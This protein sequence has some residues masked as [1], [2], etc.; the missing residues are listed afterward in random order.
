MPQEDSWD[1]LVVATASASTASEGVVVHGQL[2]SEP[3]W[4][5]EAQQELPSP[6][7]PIE[8]ACLQHQQVTCV[9]EVVSGMSSCILVS[10]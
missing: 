8:D 2:V 7:G 4:S 5:F 6:G 9:S 1:G 3:E 10:V